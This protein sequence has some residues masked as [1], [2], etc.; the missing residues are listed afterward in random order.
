MFNIY[1]DFF[2]LSETVYRDY[3]DTRLTGI[4]ISLITSELAV[5]F[6]VRAILK[7]TPAMAMKSRAPKTQ[8]TVPLPL[9]V[10]KHLSTMMRI[11]LRSVVRNPFRGFL[12]VLAVTFPFSMASVFFSFHPTINNILECQFKNIQVFDLMLSLDRYVSPEDAVASGLQ[13]DKIEKSEAVCEIPIEITNE[14]LK[15]FGI[16]YGMD[17]DMELWNIMDLNRTLYEPPE[18]GIVLNERIAN[19]LHIKK[20]DKVDVSGVRLTTGKV[21][22]SIVDV[23][24]ELFDKGCSLDRKSVV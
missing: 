1:T 15:E 22:L 8:R 16:M 3:W 23:I 10:I 2:N 17:K 9:S 13:L 4:G 24:N 6:G 18:N 11:A 5:F 14:N 19:K 21:K 20:G 12:I 7:I